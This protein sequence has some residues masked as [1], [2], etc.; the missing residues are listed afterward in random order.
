MAIYCIWNVNGLD[1]EDGD[2][3]MICHAF[4]GESVTLVEYELKATFESSIRDTFGGIEDQ[5]MMLP[6][7]RGLAEADDEEVRIDDGYLVL[8]AVELVEE[9]FEPV[10]E[11]IADLIRDLLKLAGGNCKALFLLGEFESSQYMWKRAREEFELHVGV[12][13]SPPR[14]EL[15]ISRGAVSVVLESY[16]R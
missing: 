15:V 11:N 9:V 8:D 13:R 1:L 16:P 5:L 7:I 3:F 2:R 4:E 12:I 10:M 14:P 6:A